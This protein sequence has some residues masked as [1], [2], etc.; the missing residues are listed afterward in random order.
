MGDRPATAT[1]AEIARLEHRI[2]LVGTTGG[3]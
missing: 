3:P 2:A 1:G